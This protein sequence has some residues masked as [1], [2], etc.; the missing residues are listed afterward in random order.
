MLGGT[1]LQRSQSSIDCHSEILRASGRRNPDTKHL[2]TGLLRAL[3]ARGGR[4]PRNDIAE[5]R[6][7]EL[8]RSGALPKQS[9]GVS[10][11]N[12]PDVF[13]ILI[14]NCMKKNVRPVAAPPP[15]RGGAGMTYEKRLSRALVGMLLAEI[16]SRE[17]RACT[18]IRRVPPFPDKVAKG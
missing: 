10:E 5:C 16:A 17:S 18:P 12:A 4:A 13:I 3:S 7:S 8:R 6:S 15:L 11:A 2:K 9:A 14:I 1:S